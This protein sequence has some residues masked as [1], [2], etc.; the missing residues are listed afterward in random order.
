MK[1]ASA[2]YR[3]ALA[4]FMPV[5]SI[6]LRLRS[7]AA[8]CLMRFFYMIP[9]LVPVLIPHLS[10]AGYDGASLSRVYLVHLG[11]CEAARV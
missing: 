10:H 2:G 9:Q 6:L 5:I 1:G 11:E 7:V 3:T 8:S 4:P